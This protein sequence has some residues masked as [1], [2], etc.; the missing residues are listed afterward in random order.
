MLKQV[1]KFS[2][3]VEWYANWRTSCQSCGRLLSARSVR[4]EYRAMR[5]VKYYASRNVELLNC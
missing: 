4:V 2:N 1:R 3:L 5:D